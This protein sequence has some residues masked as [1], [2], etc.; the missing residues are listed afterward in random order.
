MIFSWPLK[1]GWGQSRHGK[2]GKMTRKTM[3]WKSAKKT[4][5]KSSW[6]H[7]FYVWGHNQIDANEFQSVSTTSTF[8]YTR[9]DIQKV[10]NYVYRH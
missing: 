1:I 10:L 4:H 6:L 2:K 9:L 5:C 7:H 8:A 3:G